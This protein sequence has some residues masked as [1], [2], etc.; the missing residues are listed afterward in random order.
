MFSLSRNISLSEVEVWY[1]KTG[2]DEVSQH[3]G[4]EG[5]VTRLFGCFSTSEFMGLVASQ[6]G[7][8]EC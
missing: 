3:A 4:K 2:V 5:T 1:S 8:V 7:I 6:A